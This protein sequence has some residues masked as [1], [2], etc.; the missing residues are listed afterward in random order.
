MSPALNRSSAIWRFEGSDAI[1]ICGGIIFDFYTGLPHMSNIHVFMKCVWNL[2]LRKF[3]NTAPWMWHQL[4]HMMQQSSVSAWTVTFVTVLVSPT[5]ERRGETSTL[6][7][8]PTGLKAK[9]RS[10]SP[11]DQPSRRPRIKRPTSKKVCMHS[12]YLEQWQVCSREDYSVVKLLSYVKLAQMNR[13]QWGSLAAAC[14]LCG[15]SCVLQHFK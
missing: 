6:S 13:S 5:T 9:S 1:E 11:A 7:I 12:V 4:K 10:A 14:S 2:P 8:R 3:R 15:A